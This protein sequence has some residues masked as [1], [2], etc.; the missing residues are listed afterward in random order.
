MLRNAFGGYNTGTGIQNTTNTAGTVTIAYY[1]TTG[2]LAA[3][4]TNPIAANGYLGIYQ[5]TD[6]PADGAYTAKITSDVAIAA[7][8]NEVAPSG[9]PAVQ[10]S[11]AY[12]TFAA[13]S[14]SLHLP[15]VESGG[16]DGWSTGEGIM[17]TGAS[18]TTVTVTYYDAASGLQ[19]GTPD[20]LL[21]QPNA[22][23][24]LYQPAGGLPSGDRA[25][26]TVT[27]SA[28]G[29]VAVICN[30]SNSTSFMSYTAQ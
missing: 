14:S 8:V 15:L 6:I 4:T 16:A 22:F 18:A 28:G 9:N 11:T 19:V 23:W 2:A 13:G 5:G 7:I 24:G 17:N 21:L 10:Q 20:I 27:T 29:Q 1:G 26:A 12:N 3:T 30:E 25:S